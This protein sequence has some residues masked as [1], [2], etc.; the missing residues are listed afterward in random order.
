MLHAYGFRVSLALMRG[1]G[2]VIGDLVEA[3]NLRA[4]QCR[5]RG[6]HHG[7][8]WRTDEDV[9]VTLC[10]SYVITAILLTKRHKGVCFGV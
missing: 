9:A 10:P 6:I 1:H 3:K 2:Y 5:F 7:V 8:T 4:K